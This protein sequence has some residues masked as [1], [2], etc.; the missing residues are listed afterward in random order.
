MKSYSYSDAR[1]HLAVLL[2]QAQRDGA[3]RIRR[4]DGRTF[5]ILPEQSTTSPLDVDGVDI[6]I[7]AAEIVAFVHE[8]R[9][10][11]SS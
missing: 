9:R 5:V 4:H 11:T 7:T 1:Q 3:V 2:E 6:P 8:G 10:K